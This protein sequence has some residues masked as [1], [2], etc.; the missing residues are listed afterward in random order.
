MD[1]AADAEGAN[2]ITDDLGI[3]L[4]EACREGLTFDDKAAGGIRVVPM[5]GSPP[6]VEMP[7]FRQN[8]SYG[9]WYY[10]QAKKDETLPM[11]RLLLRDS[12][13]E[14]P[15]LRDLACRGCSFCSLIYTTLVEKKKNGFNTRLN[16]DAFQRIVIEE[17]KGTEVC[18]YFS[19]Y[20]WTADFNHSED[21]L[22]DL[23]LYVA[24]CHATRLERGVGLLFR[25][26]PCTIHGDGTC[27]TLFTAKLRAYQAS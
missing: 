2:G 15:R 21:D 10:P 16:D 12:S 11:R 13:P 20:H 14:F 27:P 22:G 6:Y 25:L 18:I 17:G 19:S 1:P 23:H 7:G 24:I 8:I 26:D 9:S 4:C 3:P 5:D